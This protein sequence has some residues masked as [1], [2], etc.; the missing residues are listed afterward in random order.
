MD[1]AM[2]IGLTRQMTLRRAMDVVANNIANAN[3]AGFKAE[4][5]LHES[6]IHH[7]AETRENSDDIHYVNVRGLGR[8][9]GQGELQL[10]RR[11]LDMAI[12]GDGLFAAEMDDGQWQYM[13]D[14]RFHLDT[15]G[16]LVTFD[17]R[18]VMD[19]DTGASIVLDP[20]ISDIQIVDGG[21]VMQDGVQMGRIGVFDVN[22]L[23]GLSKAGSGRYVLEETN[24]G[25]RPE[26]MINPAVRQGFVE[27][28]NVQPVLEL[29]RMMT[30][31]R[32][33]QSVTKFLNDANELSRSAIERLAK[34]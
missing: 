31:S 29:T 26:N 13:R 33:Y 34:V 32:T 2:M 25:D 24:G 4:S 11:P 15:Q 9:F 23:G 1:N 7:G 6:H 27:A 18:P 28:S 21:I 30:V 22:N 10:T 3:T 12:E 8:D 5:L 16:T 19:G 17:G 14:G 20:G